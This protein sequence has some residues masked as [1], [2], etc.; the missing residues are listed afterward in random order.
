MEFE[1]NILGIFKFLTLEQLL[2]FFFVTTDK[3]IN[4]LCIIY[5]YAILDYYDNYIYKYKYKQ[6]RKN[7][8]YLS[9]N[10]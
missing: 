10:N 9:V 1:I 7:P 8:L 2:N 3:I 6:V 5:Y 4:E